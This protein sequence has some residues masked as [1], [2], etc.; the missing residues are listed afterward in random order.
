MSCTWQPSLGCM[1]PNGSDYRHA[2]RN[3]FERETASQRRARSARDSCARRRVATRQRVPVDS[4]VKAVSRGVGSRTR[5]RVSPSPRCPARPS[6]ARPRPVLFD[7]AGWEGE[8]PRLPMAELFQEHG[9]KQRSTPLH[10]RRRVEVS[11]LD[12]LAYGELAACEYQLGMRGRGEMEKFGIQ[13]GRTRFVFIV[14]PGLLDER[15]GVHVGLVFDRRAD[16]FDGLGHARRVAIGRTC[17]TEPAAP[18][19]NRLLDPTCRPSRRGQAFGRHAL[20][21]ITKAPFHINVIPGPARGNMQS[22]STWLRR[23][24]LRFFQVIDR[25][26]GCALNGR[27]CAATGSWQASLTYRKLQREDRVARFTA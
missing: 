14:A 21:D 23:R 10:A 6:D 1:F 5:I 16:R 19:D 11:V 9:R 27:V 25:L 24:P 18:T 22:S 20:K 12:G 13:A 26:G 2:R 4:N 3:G 15:S 7:C 17:R 8:R